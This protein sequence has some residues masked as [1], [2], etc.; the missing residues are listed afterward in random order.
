MDDFAKQKLKETLNLQQPEKPTI[1]KLASSI[2]LLSKLKL[3]IP[4]QA[5]NAVQMYDLVESQFNGLL[6]FVNL[7]KLFA[8]K[9]IA[10]EAALNL[11]SQSFEILPPDVFAGN[12]NITDL[13]NSS[14]LIL[15]S[16]STNTDILALGRLSKMNC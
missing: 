10:Q 9:D 1:L 4:M 8:V 2:N 3:N 5:F 13:C 11:D 12:Q 14:M 16:N 6:K 15:L 7:Q